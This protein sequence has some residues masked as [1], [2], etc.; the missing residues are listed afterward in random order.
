MRKRRLVPLEARVTTP[1]VWLL[2]AVLVA[3]G[4]FIVLRVHHAVRAGEERLLD[5]VA[6]VAAETRGPLPRLAGIDLAIV[7]SNGHV[8]LGTLP[9][10]IGRRELDARRPT[11]RV[12]RPSTRRHDRLAARSTP[13]RA[14]PSSSSR[15]VG[16]RS[17]TSPAS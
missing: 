11:G 3:I 5:R 13:R 12:A 2:A 17:R 1:V 7:S 10:A 15:R 9:V 4:G 16:F 8:L 6:A 14:S